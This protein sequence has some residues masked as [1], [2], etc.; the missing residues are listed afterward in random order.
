MECA[1]V[2]LGPRDD[3]R[4]GRLPGVCV[5]CTGES[6][7]LKEGLP[8]TGNREMEWRSECK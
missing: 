4:V 6:S 3:S 7:K 5:L 2:I 8:G 1:S